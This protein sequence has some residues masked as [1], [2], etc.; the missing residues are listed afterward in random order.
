M[1][2][3]MRSALLVL[4]FKDNHQAAVPVP[5]GT[6]VDVLFGADDRFVTVVVDGEEFHAFAEDIREQ[7]TLLQRGLAFLPTPRF[8]AA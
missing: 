1:K 3:Y 7:G 8:A 2:C 5:A 4:A 6:I